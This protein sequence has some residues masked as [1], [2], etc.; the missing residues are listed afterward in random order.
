MPK[1][2][3]RVPKGPGQL[4]DEASAITGEKDCGKAAALALLQGDVAAHNALLNWRPPEWGG[5]AGDVCLDPHQASLKL[6]RVISA[7]GSSFT[8]RSLTTP[9]AVDQALLEERE[10]PPAHLL[11]VPGDVDQAPPQESE[12]RRVRRGG[13][14][15]GVAGE[16]E[17]ARA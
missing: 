1:K 16:P 5:H 17:T 3:R 4:L 6:E 11:P 13:R 9:A 2:I 14:A 15:G 10:G 8:V 7:S 12:D